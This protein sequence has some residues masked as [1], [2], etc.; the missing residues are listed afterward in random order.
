MTNNPK[1]IKTTPKG[2]MAALS[3]YFIW[4]CFPFYFKKLD[5]YQP[6][7][8][9]VHRIIWTFVALFLFLC[10]TQQWQFIQILKEKPKWLFMTFLSGL[11][12]ATNWVCYVWAVNNNQ[13]LEASLGYFISPLMGI[14]LSF[15]ILKEPLKKLQKI[16]IALALT[17]VIIQMILLGTLPII[18]FVL[19]ISFSIYG[20]LHRNN[21]LSASAALWIET[22][23][24]LPLGLIWLFSHESASRHYELWLSWDI[25]LLMAAGPITLIPLLLYNQATKLVNFNTLSFMQY[26]TPLAIFVI[27]IFYY[28]EHFDNQRMFVFI[29]IWL[30]LIIYSIDIIKHRAKPHHA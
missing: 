18:A 28:Q 1:L 12:I 26:I 11:L 16:A 4:S 23:L 22:A 24:L 3:A 2:M 10:I 25:F 30:A 20:V 14:I 13:I 6:L 7:E 21:P 5:A 27:A 15:F 8:I 17:A 19:A 9:I 29:M